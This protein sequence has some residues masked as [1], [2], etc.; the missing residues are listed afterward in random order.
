MC[1]AYGFEINDEFTYDDTTALKLHINNDEND[2]SCTVFV[3]DG[4]PVKDLPCA[5]LPIAIDVPAHPIPFTL[6]VQEGEL[7]PNSDSA[8]SWWKTVEIN[9][10]NHTRLNPDAIEDIFLVCQYTGSVKTP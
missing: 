9:G 3:G 2:E 4:S 10:E 8:T 6:E 5:K 1:I 7:P